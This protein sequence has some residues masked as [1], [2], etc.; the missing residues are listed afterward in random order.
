MH[1]RFSETHARVRRDATV[2]AS[3][4]ENACVCVC[5]SENEQERKNANVEMSE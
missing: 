2:K 5:V 4:R 1:W 3:D